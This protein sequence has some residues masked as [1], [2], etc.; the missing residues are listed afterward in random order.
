MQKFL[1]FGFH[2]DDI[3]YCCC[4]TVAKLIKQD[5][6]VV[7]CIVTN[8]GKGVNG[9]KSHIAIKIRQKEQKESARIVGVDKLIFLNE[10]DGE[11]ENTK[12]LRK[13][14]VAVIR[15]E[16]PEIIMTFEPY[17][18]FDDLYAMHRDHRE[19]TMAVFDAAYPA[20]CTPS[21]FPELL[22]KGLEPHSI[23]EFW[24]YAPTR[25]NYFINIASVLNL[26]IQALAS[27]MSQVKT[28]EIAKEIR[29][30][31]AM[32]GRPK[33]IKYAEAFR[34]VNMDYKDIN[35][36]RVFPYC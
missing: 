3:E 16:K 22:K 2:P 34:R 4:A 14:L 26:K 20:S 11:L 19:G 32:M 24:F 10:V 5:N 25:P 30:F 12:K 27:H 1:V 7:Y 21:Y 29:E 28:H 35:N 23:K 31:A 8:G 33:K 6:K 9:K 15:S 36:Y 17:S 18:H 13:K